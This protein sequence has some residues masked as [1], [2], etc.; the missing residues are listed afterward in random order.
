MLGIIF[1]G[2]LLVA[3]GMASRLLLRWK[4]W[5]RNV[6]DGQNRLPR[7]ARGRRSNATESDVRRGVFAVSYAAIGFGILVLAWAFYVG[8]FQK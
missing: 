2:L 7:I 5:I 3:F 6:I 4:R 8:V 1:V